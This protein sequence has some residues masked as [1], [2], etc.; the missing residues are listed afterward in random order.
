M[1]A[2]LFKRGNIARQH[3]QLFERVRIGEREYSSQRA[4]QTAEMC[5]TA[6][7]LTEF[8]RY[9]ADVAASTDAHTERRLHAIE[10]GDRKGTD[11][12]LCSSQFDRLAGASELVSRCAGNLFCGERR[13]H[14]FD[15][16]AETCRGSAN[17]FKRQRWISP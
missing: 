2:P 4:A 14:L 8:M 10:G 15:F 13:R 16:A 17:H 11:D 3:L 6:E 9:R 12:Y 5:A 7:V 1:Q